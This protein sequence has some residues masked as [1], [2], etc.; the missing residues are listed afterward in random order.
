[1]RGIPG[2][3]QRAVAHRFDDKAAHRDHPFLKYLAA[4]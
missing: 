3:M 1:M 2:E 4:G